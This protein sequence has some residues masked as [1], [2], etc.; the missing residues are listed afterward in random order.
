MYNER[1]HGGFG[2]QLLIH[3][4]WNIEVKGGRQF[5]GAG[6]RW[7]HDK[8]LLKES[9]TVLKS[10]LNEFIIWGNFDQ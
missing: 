10:T 8:T 7:A 5:W 2:E 3:Y 4:F 6:Q 1:D 9:D